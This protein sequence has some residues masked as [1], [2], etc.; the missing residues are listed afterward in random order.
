VA[1][2]VDAMGWERVY[3]GKRTVDFVKAELR[4]CGGIHF[5]PDIAA[6]AIRLLDSGRMCCS[7]EG[8]G[9]DAAGI[10]FVH[11]LTNRPIH[12]PVPAGH[13]VGDGGLPSSASAE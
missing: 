2:A 9:E 6:L 4:R 10:L 3:H 8:E 11:G 1:D 12:M 5:D 13:G 7:N